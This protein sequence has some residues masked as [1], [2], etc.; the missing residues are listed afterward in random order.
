MFNEDSRIDHRLVL[1]SFSV[2]KTESSRRLV[3]KNHRF[4]RTCDNRTMQGGREQRPSAGAEPERVRFSLCCGE[5]ERQQ[6]T[7]WM[8]AATAGEI[9]GQ[10]FT[11]S[12]GPGWWAETPCTTTEV[13]E[14]ERAHSPPPQ[15]SSTVFTTSYDLGCVEIRAEFNTQK[16]ADKNALKR[17]NSQQSN[18]ENIC[19]T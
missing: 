17:P 7:G 6:R 3:T 11:G 4:N 5:V 18:M 12:K 13:V 15:A 8:P 1:C 10:S 9:T 16:I 14:P 19:P 2:I